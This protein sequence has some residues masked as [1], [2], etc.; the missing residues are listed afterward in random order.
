MGSRWCHKVWNEPL[1]LY[2][3][4]LYLHDQKN[5]DKNSDILT[6]KKAF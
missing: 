5:Q 4:A 6:P 3:A 2:Q 1:L